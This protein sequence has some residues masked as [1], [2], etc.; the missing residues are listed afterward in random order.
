MIIDMILI[1]KQED[2]KIL[3]H[4]HNITINDVRLAIE[5]KKM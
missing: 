5:H 2:D 1:N 3:S 4:T